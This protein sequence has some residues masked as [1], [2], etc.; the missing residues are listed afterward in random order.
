MKRI[1]LTLRPYDEEN[2]QVALILN[3]SIANQT[4]LIRAAI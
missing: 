3:P 2:L 1:N 4:D